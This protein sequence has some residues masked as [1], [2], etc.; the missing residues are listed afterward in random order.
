MNS[1]NCQS[2]FLL[3]LALLLIHINQDAQAAMLCAFSG[4]FTQS[5]V[6]LL[7]LAGTKSLDPTSCNVF[8]HCVLL[9]NS[10]GDV[11]SQMNAHEHQSHRSHHHDHD[12]RDVTEQPQNLCRVILFRILFGSHD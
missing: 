2:L 4:N 12:E 9:S 8:L 5:T 6:A 7:V 1:F 10:D 3:L 11:L